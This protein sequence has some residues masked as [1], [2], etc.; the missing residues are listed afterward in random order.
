MDVATVSVATWTTAP[1]QAL[2]RRTLE[3]MLGVAP[4]ADATRGATFDFPAEG[5]LVP[6]APPAAFAWHTG[7]AT[8][9]LRGARSP[10]ALAS[11]LM[12][13]GPERSAFAHGK[14]V[15][16]NGFF[17]VF[18]TADNDKV[19]RVF[20]T[21]TSYTPDDAAWQK[22]VGAGAPVT[23]TILTAVFENNFLVSDGGPFSGTPVT[24]TIE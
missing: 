2:G 4:V 7:G 1:E 19:L 15:N 23:A 13:V 5:A 14:P 18:S 9:I 20:T 21:S 6:V 22:L 12:L 16:G 3:Q 17:L 10:N 11:A 24:F 8:G